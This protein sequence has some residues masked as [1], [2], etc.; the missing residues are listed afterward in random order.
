MNKKAAPKKAPKT[1]KKAARKGAKKTAKKVGKKAVKK[2]APKPAKKAAKKGAA[3][4][5]KKTSPKKPK[6]ISPKKAGPTKAVASV[7]PASHAVAAPAETHVLHVVGS[8]AAAAAGP[9]VGDWAPQFTV[10]ADDGSTVSLKDFA[11][12]KIVLY[13]YPKDDTPGCTREACDFR[14]SLGRLAIEKA[15]VLGV[16]KDDVKSHRK[17]REKYGL[18]FSLLA[19][20]DGKICEAYGVIKDKSMYGRVTRGIERTTFLIGQ[21]GKIAKIYPKVRVEGHV[22]ALIEDLKKI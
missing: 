12:R 15:V 1:A 11:G 7:K 16:S 21:D 22:D 4:A 18:N 5:Q 14:D 6:K 17:F 9:A 2:A 13:F 3:K 8:E 19:D 20:T 10:E